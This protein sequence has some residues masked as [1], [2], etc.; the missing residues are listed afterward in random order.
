MKPFS[1]PN[2]LQ[3]DLRLMDSKPTVIDRLF[4]RNKPAK[5]ILSIKGSQYDF[6]RCEILIDDVK[7]KVQGHIPHFGIDSI[8]SLLYKQFLVYVIEGEHETGDQIVPLELARELMRKYKFYFDDKVI[9][10]E[11]KRK[12][13]N[14]WSLAERVES[15][16]VA[17][18][19]S[20]DI[21]MNRTEALRGEVFLMDL[22]RLDPEF[23]LTLEQ[24]ISTLFADF[25]ASVKSGNQRDI[26]NGIIDSLSEI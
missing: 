13:T 14:H 5:T 22:H 20:I 4:G 21:T 19:Y 16:P 17:R 6:F 25:M 9:S 2:L 18:M 8:V 15:K 12:S 7:R 10:Q 1:K 23:F 26:L 3:T 11:L 24:V